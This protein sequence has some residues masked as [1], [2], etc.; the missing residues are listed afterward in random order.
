MFIIFFM[1]KYYVSFLSFF[2]EAFTLEAVLKRQFWKWRSAYFNHT[3]R[4]FIVSMS[5][6]RIQWP[7]N[8]DNIIWANIKSRQ[9]FLGFKIYICWDRAVVVY[10]RALLT[11]LIIKQIFFAKKSE[12]SWLFTNNG[13]ISGIWVPLTNVFSIFQWVFGAVLGAVKIIHKAFIIHNILV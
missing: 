7:Y 2:R 5:L 1:C 11:K 12:T 9:T 4:Y 8:L 6:I 10:C 3:D 13:G